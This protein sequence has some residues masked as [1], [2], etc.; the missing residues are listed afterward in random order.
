M[1][2]VY[3][4]GCATVCGMS[5]H[6]VVYKESPYRYPL[7]VLILVMYSPDEYGHR[8]ILVGQLGA[9]QWGTTPFCCQGN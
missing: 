3:V 5:Y 7:C 6:P 9:S 2:I 8:Q 4:V 1:S